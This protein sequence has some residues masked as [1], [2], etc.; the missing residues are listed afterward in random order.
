MTGVC[1]LRSATTIMLDCAGIVLRQTKT[2]GNL[3]MIELFTR[4]EGKLGAGTHLSESGKSKSALAI[5]PFVLGRYHLRESSQGF[6]KIA[7]AETTDAHFAIGQNADRFTEAS[8][9]LEFI[10]RVLPERFRAPEIFDLLSEYLAL[11]CV[12]AKDFRVL[13]LSFLTKTMQDTGVLPGRDDLPTVVNDDILDYVIFLMENP[14]SRVG[15]LMLDG[16]IETKVFSA[17]MSLAR[18]NLD[19]GKLKSEQLLTI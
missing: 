14:L 19:I 11:L 5:R 10:D 2:T 9:A 1:S 8:F 6:M 17:L 13:T 16:H 18:R 3:R 15:K 12:R 4:E 7:S